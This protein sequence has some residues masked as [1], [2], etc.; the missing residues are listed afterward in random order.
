MA[1]TIIAA[2][3]LRTFVDLTTVEAPDAV[4]TLIASAVNSYIE[5]DCSRQ[6]SYSRRRRFYEATN[7][8]KLR[9]KE[10]PLT[11]VYR[12]VTQLTHA[13]SVEGPDVRSTISVDSTNNT[14]YLTPGTGSEIEIDI[15][16]ASYDTLLELATE[17]ATNAGWTTTMVNSDFDSYPAKELILIEA[18]L[19]YSSSPAR[20]YIPHPRASLAVIRAVDD[21]AALERIDGAPFDGR[22]WLDYQAGYETVPD[23]LKRVALEIG[24]EWFHRLQRDTSLSSESVEGYSWTANDTKTTDV[25]T[26]VQ[27][28]HGHDPRLQPWRKMEI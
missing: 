22:V 11:R 25:L 3:D 28:T 14:V 15:S 24:A 17:I 27:N 6:F 1:L 8:A 21:L 16:N 4:L 2:S 20:L 23:D 26:K 18:Q 13:I 9:I 5:K 12:C 10:Y 19:C 7:Y